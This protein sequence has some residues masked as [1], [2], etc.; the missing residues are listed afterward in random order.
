M[1]HL[2]RIC[3]VC[4]DEANPSTASANFFVCQKCGKV[5]DVSQFDAKRVAKLAMAGTSP[6]TG[7]IVDLTMVDAPNG[8]VRFTSPLLGFGA[9]QAADLR[10]SS[11]AIRTESDW[12]SATSCSDAGAWGDSPG[13]VGKIDTLTFAAYIQSQSLQGGVTIY[14]AVRVRNSGGALG[15]IS[16]SISGTYT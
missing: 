6:G 8:I 1:S 3:P 7:R 13:P 15:E 2:A 12:T 11:S 9:A 10:V 14:L 4:G 16:N 5:G